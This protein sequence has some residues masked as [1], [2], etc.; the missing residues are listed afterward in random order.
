MIALQEIG[1][2]H[3]HY[4]FIE[5][6]LHT[7]FPV[8]ER[9]DDDRQRWNA[10]NEE[11]FHCLLALD[12][13]SPVGVLTYWD[14][15]TFIYIEHLAIDETLRGKG[16]GK[17]VLGT[18]F[19]SHTKPVV[20]E[21][22]HPTDETSRRRIGFYKRCGLHLWECD[23]CQPP[24]RAEDDWFPMYLM[25]TRGASFENDYP[26]MR[27]TIYHKVYGADG[28]QTSV[29]PSINCSKKMCSPS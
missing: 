17:D 5:E 7:A 28:R 21:V 15:D 23:Y 1:T 22:E 16:Y 9:R 6:L 4:T 12:E 11:Q 18:F 19:G 20:L 27:K 14:F 3:P 26:H 10:D 8:N 25:V 13:K 24:Y 29:T 2:E